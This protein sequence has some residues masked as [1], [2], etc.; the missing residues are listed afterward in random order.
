MSKRLK[1]TK[2]ILQHYKTNQIY[3][4]WKYIHV[5]FFTR[6]LWILVQLCELYNN[7]PL[8]SSLLIIQIS[9]FQLYLASQS[10][11]EHHRESTLVEVVQDQYIEPW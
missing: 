3:L 11:L 7:F 4:M 9:T 8:V 2:Q 5:F 10:L 1:L 6:H